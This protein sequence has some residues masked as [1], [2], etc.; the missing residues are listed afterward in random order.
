[1]ARSMGEIERVSRVASDIRGVKGLLNRM[2]L[3]GSAVRPSPVT[4]LRVVIGSK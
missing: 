1:M 4:G 3:E 2:T